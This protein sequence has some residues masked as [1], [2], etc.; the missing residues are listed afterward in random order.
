MT[1]SCSLWDVLRKCCLISAREISYEKAPVDNQLS[2][3]F[4]PVI[5]PE[6]IDI[7]FVTKKNNE[8]FSFNRIFIRLKFES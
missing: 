8:N 4:V 7:A 6:K 2:E 5:C 1:A 3:C